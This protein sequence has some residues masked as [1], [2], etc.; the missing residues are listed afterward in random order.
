MAAPLA[1]PRGES[2][3]P[4]AEF[5][6]LSAGEQELLLGLQQSILE[7]VAQGK[8]A[9]T[10]IEDV[11]RL[12][13]QLLPNAV[14][15]VMLLDERQ[16]LNV[17]AA[18]SIPPAGAA[19]L[20]GL[21]PGPQA[22]SCGN[23]IYREE[24]VFVA[25]TLTDPRWENLRPIAI[26]FG[27]MACWS[28]PIRAAGEKPVGTFALSSFERRSPSPF[29]RKM[30]E[31]G[32]SIIGIVLERN[33]QAD[34]IRLLNR[35]F[36]S[37]NEAIMITD[38]AGH[39]ISINQAFTATT[40]YCA[41][42]VLGRNPRL[43]SSGRHD[44]GFYRAM[45]QSIGQ[46][47]H[48]Q[49]EIWNRRR[50]GEI[51]PQWINISTIH[52]DAGQITHYLGV[53]TDI[54]ER[55][56]AQAYIDFLSHHDALTGLP[57]RLLLKDR[58]GQAIAY[59][60]RHGGKVALLLLDID[61]FKT[62]NDTLGHGMG[63]ELLQAVAT[64]LRQGLGKSATVSRQGGDEFLI[65]LPDAPDSPAIGRAMD[66]ILERLHAPFSLRGQEM[67]VSASIGA[68]IY[69]DDGADFEAL[70]SK[71][72]M[73]MYTAKEAGRNTGAFFDARMNA[74]ART[75][76]RLLNDLARALERR[77]LVLHYQPQVDLSSGAI[78]G[79]E[80]LIRWQH[81]EQGL[82]PPGQFIP[83]AEESGLIVPIGEWVLREA[84]RQA[85]AWQGQG[86]PPLV[87]AVNLSALQFKR[88]SLIL[89]VAEALA[90]TGLAPEHLELE[91]TESILIKDTEN[92]LQTVQALRGMGI[93]LSV[94]DFGTGYSSLAYLKRFAVHKLKIDRSF[95]HN[96][97]DNPDDAAIVRAIIQMARSLNLSTIAEGVED[98]RLPDLLRQQGCTEA[99]GF[100]FARP[101]PAADLARR[102]E[103]HR[104]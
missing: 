74:D 101:L 98:P 92:V 18:P 60:D 49:G 16:Q 73:A 64:R 14:G 21:R 11:C 90:E 85:A 47:G 68:A 67:A 1:R 17:Y 43:L 48:W 91:L 15:S 69:P 99:Q 56:E 82:L 42:E 78:I 27:L 5:C 36:D 63:D 30:L 34:H 103:Q 65:V 52:D 55:K 58:L 102:L 23:A 71:A 79:V 72:D 6:E 7:A 77:E 86:L 54:T 38:A 12:E 3:A 81:P 24:P 104:P 96:M 88:G 89:T 33:R 59:A 20:N 19:R 22:G 75:N 2:P 84:C 8:D 100:L 44:H 13:E 31:I 40:G 70:F 45:W 61:N 53:L 39:I 57:N 62:V 9:Q 41:P 83:L 66:G 28:I 46:L 25:D 37:S 80:A 95:V 32:A 94:D 26:D 87:M 35:A 51:Y 76:L 4:A 10:I 50:N 93:R 29:H 97:A